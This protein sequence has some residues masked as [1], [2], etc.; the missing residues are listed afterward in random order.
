MRPYLMFRPLAVALLA[1][2]LFS[3]VSHGADAPARYAPQQTLVAVLPVIDAT[4]GKEPNPKA[5]ANARTSI[6]E[7]LTR[8]GFQIVPDAAVTAAVSDLKADLTD[9]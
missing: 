2:L 8:R 1:T 3:A 6:N 9:E 7:Q 5:V 4:G